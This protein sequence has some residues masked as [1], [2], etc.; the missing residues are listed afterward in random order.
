MIKAFLI[1]C[2]FACIL[3]ASEDDNTNNL[4]FLSD[5]KQEICDK[6]ENNFELSLYRS[7]RYEIK[8][9]GRLILNNILPTTGISVTPYTAI[10]LLY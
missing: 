2:V 7:E 1:L 9:S 5:E 8:L 6:L 4:F 10:K 3:K